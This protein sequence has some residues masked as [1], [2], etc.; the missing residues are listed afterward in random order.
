MPEAKPGF[1]SPTNI[2][3]ALQEAAKVTALLCHELSKADG[4]A[5]R[6]I[7]LYTGDSELLDTGLQQIMFWQVGNPSNPNYVPGFAVQI[8]QYFSPREK[9][10]FPDYAEITLVRISLAWYTEP[11]PIDM[12]LPPSF[13][14]RMIFRD[15]DMSGAVTKDFIPP[16]SWEDPQVMLL[17]IYTWVKDTLRDMAH[18][19]SL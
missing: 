17:E 11:P 14:S 12:S 3:S 5:P 13:N 18:A 15:G 2:L 8:M 4:P 10:Y 16:P 19:D 6:A 1:Y 7:R 9:A